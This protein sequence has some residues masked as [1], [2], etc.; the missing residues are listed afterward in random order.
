MN[1][2]ER[3]HACVC[4]NLFVSVYVWEC[5]YVRER[6]STQTCVQCAGGGYIY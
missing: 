5:V 6:V 2:R 4:V 1:D 3:E